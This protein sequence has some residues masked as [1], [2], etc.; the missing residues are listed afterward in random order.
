[1]V[2]VVFAVVVVDLE[3]MEGKEAEIECGFG[4]ALEEVEARN[5]VHQ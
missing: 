4:A 5:L 3:D 2:A 1:M